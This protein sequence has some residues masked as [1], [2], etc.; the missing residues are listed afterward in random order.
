AGA[1]ATGEGGHAV[2]HGINLWD[3][4][5][6]RPEIVREKTPLSCRL[7]A[8]DATRTPRMACRP[9]Q[10]TGCLERATAYMADQPPIMSAEISLQQEVPMK[11]PSGRA[12]EQL[13]QIRITRN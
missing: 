2:H 3:M 9:A 13:R 5:N 10:S 1:L 6:E 11:R 12:A 8:L 4:G 7:P